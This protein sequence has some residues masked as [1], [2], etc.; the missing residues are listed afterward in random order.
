MCLNRRCVATPEAQ[1]V[2]VVIEY[3]GGAI[4]RERHSETAAVLM[5]NIL[6]SDSAIEQTGQ[7]VWWADEYDAQHGQA[8]S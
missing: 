4:K 8:A 5:T 2:D 1:W 7:R 6:G 3:A